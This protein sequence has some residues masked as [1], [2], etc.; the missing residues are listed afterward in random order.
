M[1]QIETRI[2]WAIA[3]AARIF[4]RLAVSRRYFSARYVL[5]RR[6]QPEIAADTSAVFRKTFP[7]RLFPERFLPALSLFPGQRPAQEARC[8]GEAKALMSTPISAMIVTAL[9]HSTPG[10]LISNPM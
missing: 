1:C 10:M 8:A 7:F 3:T 5:P 9:I 2:L 4:P 6:R